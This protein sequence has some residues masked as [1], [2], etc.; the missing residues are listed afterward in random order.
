VVALLLVVAGCGGTKTVTTTVTRSSS[1]PA[2]ISQSAGAPAGKTIGA[3][4]LCDPADWALQCSLSPPAN[5]LGVPRPSA[6][7][8]FGQGVD[9]AW[10]GPSV[11]AL[12]ANGKRFAVG[13]FSYDLS[14]NWQ[15]WQ[16]RAYRAAGIATVGVFESSQFRPLQGCA[17]GKQDAQTAKQQEAQVGMAGAPVYSAVDFDTSGQEWRIRPYFVCWQQEMTPSLSGAYGGI[18]TIRYLFNQRLIRWGWQAYAWSAG[19]WDSRAQLQQYLNDVFIGGV[20]TDLDRATAKDYGQVPR[21]NVQPTDPFRIMDP[22]RRHFRVRAYSPVWGASY[23]VVASEHNTMATI[24]RAGCHGKPR[25]PTCK[26]SKFHLTLLRG[27][28]VR[29]GTREHPHYRLK[30]QGARQTIMAKQLRRMS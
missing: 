17:A 21:P 28:L 10:G 24:R 1:Q 20:D 22:T 27:R 15:P 12:K 29:V 4:H 6:Q 13:Y 18:S 5:R 8:V 2:T 3:A 11:A 19:Q 25:R 9:F 30:G 7:A 14:K 23:T 16:A 26:S